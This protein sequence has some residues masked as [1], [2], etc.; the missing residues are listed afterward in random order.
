M[1]IINSIPTY[2][3]KKESRSIILP[4]GVFQR[5]PNGNTTQAVISVTPQIHMVNSTPADAAVLLLLSWIFLPAFVVYTTAA[6]PVAKVSLTLCIM[7]NT[8]ASILS[9][10]Q[11]R[12][13]HLEN[14]AKKS[15]LHGT[16]KLAALPLSLFSSRIFPNFPLSPEPP[17]TSLPFPHSGEAA[18]RPRFPGFS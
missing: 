6:V 11:A 3:G 13:I 12:G 9:R 4:T 5:L 1:E 10:V 17:D 8:P 15:L 7:S 14:N 16:K 18:V 2:P